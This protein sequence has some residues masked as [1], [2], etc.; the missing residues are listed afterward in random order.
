MYNL[1]IADDE[2]LVFQYIQAVIEKN[3]LPLHICG[4]ASN[5][6]EALRLV[7]IY[8]PEFVMLDIN[9]PEINGLDVAERIREANPDTFIYILTA[10]KEFEYAHRAMHARV[11]DYLV[12]PI[13]PHDL[14]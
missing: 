6:K 2:Q 3:H 4:T 5:G 1:V 10:Y 11:T 12:K 14:V 7:Q 8:Q 9:M 13:K